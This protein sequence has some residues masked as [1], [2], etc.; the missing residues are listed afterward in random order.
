MLLQAAKTI[1]SGLATIGLT[2]I[3]LSPLQNNNILT[4]LYITHLITEAIKT[5]DDMIGSLPQINQLHKFLEEEVPNSFIYVN[6]KIENDI[7][8]GNNYIHSFSDGQKNNIKK[9]IYPFHIAGVYVFSTL[10]NEQYIGSSTNIYKR[11]SEHKHE[12][13]CKRVRSKLYLSEFELNDL[14]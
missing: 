4:K 11:L 10:T 13:L 3:L 14:Q 9:P 8:I 6:A 2:N 12:L 5:I 7:V 1:G